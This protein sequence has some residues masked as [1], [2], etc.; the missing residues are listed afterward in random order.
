MTKLS[1]L[2]DYFLSHAGPDKDFV[3]G[4]AT[5]MMLAGREIF[6]DEWSIDYGESIPGA[7]ERALQDDKAFVL[8]WSGYARS[9]AWTTKEYRS[10]VSRFLD[11]GDRLL[12]VV[13]LDDTDVPELVRDMKWIDGRGGDADLVADSL[14]GML[15]NDRLIA[16]QTTLDELNIR[17]EY[18]PGYGVL[19]ACPKC[20]ATVDK[21]TGWAQTDYARDDEYA[22]AKCTVCGWHG[23]GEI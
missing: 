3:K 6:L 11:N 18:F 7:I 17:M 13:R 15:G 12:L 20:G 1:S 22:G 16:M 2:H 14:M 4:V 9:S 19:L 23:G 5:R 10:A 8:F 21:I